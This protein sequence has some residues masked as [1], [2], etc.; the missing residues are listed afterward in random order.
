M[1]VLAIEVCTFLAIR[2]EVG[3]SVCIHVNVF[4]QYIAFYF[5]H[6]MELNRFSY[7]FIWIQ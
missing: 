6:S 3:V 4:I 1:C 5:L 7:W 2:L